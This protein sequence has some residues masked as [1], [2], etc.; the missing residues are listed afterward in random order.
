[1][2]ANA[3]HG[4]GAV[5]SG[6]D[7]ATS[8]GEETGRTGTR[9]CVAPLLTPK[10]SPSLLPSLL[11]PKIAAATATL[12]ATWPNTCAADARH[13]RTKGRSPLGPPTHPAPFLPALRPLRRGE[14]VPEVACDSDH[15][16]GA[17][18]GNLGAGGGEPDRGPLLPLHFYRWRGRRF[19]ACSDHVAQTQLP[20]L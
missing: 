5:L 4:E 20:G 1:M 11:T 10:P 2:V 13:R 18:D 17:L 19:L 12:P 9:S 15:R 8:V 3:T 16:P 7:P 14:V 6:D